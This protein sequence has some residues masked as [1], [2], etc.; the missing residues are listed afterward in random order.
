V[1]D[2]PSARLHQLN[3]L[4]LRA[5]VRDHLAADI[6]EAETFAPGA[7]LVHDGRAW[8]LLADS[9]AARL[10]SAVLWAQRHGVSAVGVI[11]EEATGVLARRAAEFAIDVEVWHADGR[12]LLPAVTEPVLTP[13][14]LPTNHEEFRERI[15]MGGAQPVVEHG[16]L[17]GEVRGLE[18]CRVVDDPYLNTTRLEV[19]V[20][21]HDREAF[22]ML[23]GDVPAAESLARIVDSVAHHRRPGAAQHPLN[24]LAGERLLRWRLCDEPELVGMASIEAAEPPIARANVKDA[25][26]CVAVGTDATGSRSVIVCSTGVDLD[27]VPFAADARIA[28]EAREGGQL[29]LVI[30]LPSRDLVRATEEINSALRRPAEFITVE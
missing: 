16:V 19:G 26:P 23:H 21:A 8:V 22:Q 28:V 4:K 14:V 17:V 10:G 9:P 13:A 5:L 24:R 18:V 29:P 27:V 15:A 20:G 1:T 2:D 3:A 30:A 12:S 11:A 7:A 6:G 25:V